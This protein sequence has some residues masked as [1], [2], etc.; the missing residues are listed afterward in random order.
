MAALG[1]HWFA[2]AFS[3]CSKQGL[4]SSCDAWATH[5][6]G[7][8]CGAWTLGAWASGAAACGLTGVVTTRH[9]GSSQ[10]RDRTHVPCIG[11]QILSHCTTR[12][13]WSVLN[14]KKK[15]WPIPSIQSQK[16]Y[17]RDWQCK[18]K[19]LVSSAWHQADLVLCQGW[20]H[21][22]WWGGGEVAGGEEGA[23]YQSW[24][25]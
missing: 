19:T 25:P 5:S 21:V 22:G 12:E 15:G 24:P 2:Q 16:T 17:K 11:R 18:K 23:G 3:S 4:L 6:G 1:L 14:I 10:N 9:V 8:F 7:F 20:C 13:A